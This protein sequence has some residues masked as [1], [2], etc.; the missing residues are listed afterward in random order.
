MSAPSS[1]LPDLTIWD[2]IRVCATAALEN[3]VKTIEAEISKDQTLA[4]LR[5]TASAQLAMESRARNWMVRAYTCCVKCWNWQQKEE[6]LEFRTAVYFYGLYPFFSEHVLRLLRVAAGI[7]RETITRLETDKGGY[8]SGSEQSALRNASEVYTTLM[9]SWLQDLPP[10]RKEAVVESPNPA[11]VVSKAPP[12]PYALGGTGFISAK[13]IPV[14]LPTSFPLSFPPSL[15]LKAR[16]ILADVV[17]AFPDRSKLEQLC[18]EL[19]S[20]YTGLL[21]TAVRSGIL[22][23]HAA[24]DELSAI[25][26]QLL[27][28]NCERDNDRFEIKRK[29]INSDEWHAMLKRLLECE[30]ELGARNDKPADS[31]KS[32]NATRQ[33]IDAFIEKMRESGHKITRTDIWRVAGY[34]DPT[35]FERFQRED[36]R[37]T[38]G[39]RTRF[40][41]VLN[42]SPEDFIQRLE[43]LD[44]K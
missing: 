17:R 8:L 19:V 5:N 36:Q 44:R 42:L 3:L 38:P 13:P 1:R 29:V 23:A 20:R 22:Q 30:E 39:S 10:I 14:E 31:A 35:E 6:T 7:S 24:P 2:S 25:V 32:A 28:A 26:H 16:V 41:R 15:A 34:D 9:T 12:P 37:A 33:K 4:Q 27:V 18:H 40:D 21:C 43:K 11:P